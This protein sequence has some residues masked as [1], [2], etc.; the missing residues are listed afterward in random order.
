M[1]RT[2]CPG[3]RRLTD[4]AEMLLV[5]DAEHYVGWRCA[6]CVEDARVKEPDALSPM[7]LHG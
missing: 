2:R 3:C 5:D 4:T 1:T 6:R 7:R